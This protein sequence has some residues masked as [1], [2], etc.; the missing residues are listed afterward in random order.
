VVTRRRISGVRLN[1]LVAWDSW[2]QSQVYNSMMK[3]SESGQ[4]PET[5]VKRLYR[6][7]YAE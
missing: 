1:V 4:N 6:L 2:V 7:V 3:V 5:V